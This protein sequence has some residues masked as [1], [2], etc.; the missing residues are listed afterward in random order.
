MGAE[1]PE[2]TAERRPSPL[3]VARVVREANSDLDLVYGKEGGGPIPL[4]TGDQSDPEEGAILT[5]DLG[6]YV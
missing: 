6:G 3:L 4:P 1:C 2:P 5:G